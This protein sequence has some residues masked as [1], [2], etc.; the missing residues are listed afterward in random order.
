MWKEEERE[1]KKTKGRRV[2]ELENMYRRKGRKNTKER[3]EIEEKKGSERR[4]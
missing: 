2:R 3:I 4:K 1:R